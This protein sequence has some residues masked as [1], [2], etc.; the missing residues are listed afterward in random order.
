M[1][2][3][4]LEIIDLCHKAGFAGT[5]ASNRFSAG[6]QGLVRRIRE[7]G[8]ASIREDGWK[9]FGKAIQPTWNYLVAPADFGVETREPCGIHSSR[10]AK[11]GISVDAL[12]YTSCCIGGAIDGFLKL[13]LR[14]QR[15]AD[16]FDEEKAAE[17][18]RKLCM[19]CGNGTALNA[20]QLAGCRIRGGM[21]LS[22]TWQKALEKFL[23]CPSTSLAEERRHLDGD[24]YGVFYTHH[25]VSDA[26]LQA[27]FACIRGRRPARRTADHRRAPAR[28]AISAWSKARDPRHL[29]LVSGQTELGLPHCR[30]R[31]NGSRV[32][33]GTRE[34]R[35][36]L[37][38]AQRALSVRLLLGSAKRINDRRLVYFWTNI[39]HLDAYKHDGPAAFWTMNPNGTYTFCS[40]MSGYRDA[41]LAA[42]QSQLKRCHETPDDPGQYEPDDG[43]GV[44]LTF[45][46]DEI[47][48]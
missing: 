10:N 39:K 32:A 27:A 25:K 35:R 8:K 33:G 46:P 37:L 6:S 36:L 24:V 7:E 13:G 22:P 47:G 16:L 17:Q 4:L 38:G 26:I 3:N 42:V 31:A 2:P 44:P 1:H 15:L 28:R 21:L 14:T 9:R 19:Y 30:L 12:G 40:G 43:H 18:T 45:K 11:C 41:L 29:A 34:R 20:L 5:V 48:A 23:P